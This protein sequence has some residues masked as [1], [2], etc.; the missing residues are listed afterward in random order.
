MLCLIALQGLM[1]MWS[2]HLVRGTHYWVESNYM[3]YNLLITFMWYADYMCT[4]YCIPFSILC[5]ILSEY[6]IC[7]LYAVLHSP[8]YVS[9][10]I[11]HTM[12]RHNVWMFDFHS[13]LFIL[14]I[15]L[16]VAVK[17]DQWVSL[18]WSVVDVVQ[19]TKE[20]DLLWGCILP[21]SKHINVPA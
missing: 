18:Y 9:L 20:T 7:V 10:S 19:H 17:S 8:Y 12:F 3:K 4:P 14:L 1:S 11:L 6:S 13:L 5:S 2:S 16:R 21:S 15:S